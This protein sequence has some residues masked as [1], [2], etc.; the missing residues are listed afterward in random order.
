MSYF[1]AFAGF[2]QKS[3]APL[4][5]EFARLALSQGWKKGTKTWKNERQA[6]M[7]TEFAHHVAVDNRLANWQS[8]CEEVGIAPTPESITKCKKVGHMDAPLVDRD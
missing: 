6:C 8:L 1:D 5:T 4:A 7:Q 3:T 2:E